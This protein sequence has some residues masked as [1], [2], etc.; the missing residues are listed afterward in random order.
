MLLLLAI[1]VTG[2]LVLLVLLAILGTGEHVD[3][4]AF[5]GLVFRTS[6]IFS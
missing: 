1:L 2:E 4:G 3:L 6:E 5:L